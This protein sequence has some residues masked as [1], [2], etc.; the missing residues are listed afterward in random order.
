M[1]D[2]YAECLVKREKNGKDLMIKGGSIALIVIMAWISI[3]AFVF[4]LPVTIVAAVLIYFFVF[5]R[6]DVEYEYLYVNG[7]L[8][9]DIVMAKKKRKKAQTF[10][11]NQTDVM[12]PLNSRRLEYYNNNS[13]LKVLDYSSGN[14]NAKRY[15]MITKANQQNCKVIL[16]PDETMV[17]MMKKTAP[18]KVFTD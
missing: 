11:L 8:D 13:R 4:L 7:E 9:V 14:E 5:P 6:T 12:A 15:G 17:E 18:S 1:G 2:L 10:D 16:E 3:F